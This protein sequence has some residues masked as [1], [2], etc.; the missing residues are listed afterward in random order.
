[1]PSKA[2][3]PGALQLLRKLRRSRKPDP[4]ALLELAELVE[5]LP[6]PAKALTALAADD[7]RLWAAAPARERAASGHARIL[8]IVERWLRA[9]PSRTR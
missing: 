8:A 4:A 3:A 6:Q 7:L 5:Y 2:K 1:M 9:Q